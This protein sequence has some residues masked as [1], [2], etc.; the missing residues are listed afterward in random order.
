MTSS[1]TALKA[2]TWTKCVRMIKFDRKPENE[3]IRKRK[4]TFT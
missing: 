4:D 3:K 1:V 2:A